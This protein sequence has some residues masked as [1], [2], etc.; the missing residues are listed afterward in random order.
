MPPKR[1]TGGRSK[2]PPRR[3][4]AKRSAP[5]REAPR[6]EAPRREPETEG[7]SFQQSGASPFM[8]GMAPECMMCP[9]GLF[10]FTV[11]NTRPEVMEHLMAAGNELFLAFKAVVDQTAERWEQTNSLQRITV[12]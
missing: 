4:A 8:P 11:R 6:R 12:R 3:T 5:R 1:T 9:M 2:T 7:P 10:F